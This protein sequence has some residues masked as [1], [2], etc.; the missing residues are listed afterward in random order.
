ML[1]LTS[2]ILEHSQ[3]SSISNDLIYAMTAKI[4]RRLLKFNSPID[5]RILN[6]VQYTVQNANKFLHARWSDVMNRDGQAFDLSVLK[7]L[8]FPLDTRITLPKLDEYL[9]LVTQRKNSTISVTFRPNSENIV[10]L[11]T[12]LPSCLESRNGDY[13]PYKLKA[14][15]AWVAANLTL[16]IESHKEDPSTCAKLAKLIRNYYGMANSTYSGNVEATSIMILTILELWIACDESATKICET[17]KHYGF[18][19]DRFNF[20]GLV[21]P[22]KSQMERLFRA[23]NYLSRRVVTTHLRN[24]HIFCSFGKED[25]FSVKYFD[26]STQHQDLLKD[27]QRQAMEDKNQKLREFS[28]KQ[29][30]YK[31]FMLL[32]DQNDCE[33]DEVVVDIINDF[34]E[35]RHRTNCKK[36]KYKTQAAGL[37]IKIHEWPLP[38][39]TLEAKSVVF[40]LQAPSF[41]GHWRDVTLY[42]KLDVLKYDYKT[43][44]TPSFKYPLKTYMRLSSFFTPFS[45]TQRIGLL[46]ETKPHEVTHRRDKKIAVATEDDICLDTGLLYKSYDDQRGCFVD[47]FLPTARVARMCMYK[48]PARSSSLQEFLFRPTPTLDGPK[49]NTVIASQSMCPAHMSFD[50]FKALGTIPQLRLQWQNILLQLSVPTVD[51]KTDETGLVVLQAIYQTGPSKDGNVLRIGHEIL[52]DESFAHALLAAL[53]EALSRTKENWESSNALS[54][55]ISLASRLLSLTSSEHIKDRSLAYL[56]DVR[57]VSFHWVNLLRERT[58]QAINDSQRRDL[59][60]KAVEL[61]LICV[62]SFNLEDKY[63]KDT[64]IDPETAS[65]FIQ[66]SIV[67]QEGDLSTSKATNTLISILSNRWK[68]NA[69]RCYLILEKELL[70]SKA[71]SLDNAIKKSWSAYQS[72]HGWQVYGKNAEYWLVSKTA[73]GLDGA[74]NPLS[75][76]FNLLTFELLVNGVPLARLPS[77]YESHSMYRILF[78]YSAVEV[79]PTAVPG[80]RYSGKKE[81]YGYTIHFGF[82]TVAGISENDLLVQA[83]KDDR[84]YE[85]LPRRVFRGHFPVAFVEDFIHWYDSTNDSVEFR[86]IEDPWATSSNKFKNYWRLSR[87]SDGR[88]WHLNRDGLSLIGFTS[89]TA[90][91]L[92]SILAPIENSPHIHIILHQ[93]S[94]TLEIEL[95]RIQLGFNLSSNSSTIQS[96]QFRGMSIDSSQS[97]GTLIGFR[98]KLILKH[99]HNDSRLIVLL[100]GNVYCKSNG[101]HVHVNIDIES[102]KRTHAFQVDDLIGRLI[103][104]GSLHSKLL[105][106]YLHALTS[107]C[108][109]DPLLQRT[110]T[111][112]ALSILRSAA[113]RS[114]DRLTEENVQI[115]TQL[116]QLTPSRCYYPANER[117]MQTVKW[118]S[119][120]DFLAQHGSFYKYV[121]SIFDQAAATSFFHPDVKLPEL[122]HV[123]SDLLERESMRS[124]TF[125]VSGFGAKEHNVK[126]DAIYTARDRDQNSKQGLNA[127]LM[128]RLIYENRTTLHSDLQ[129]DFINNLWGYLKRSPQILGPKHPLPLSEVKYDGRLLSSSSAFISRH[130]IGLHRTL[131]TG[132]NEIKPQ[133]MIWLSTLAF[134]PEADMQ[135]IQ[136]LSSFCTVSAMAHVRHPMV[137]SFRLHCG[138]KVN[139]AELRTTVQSSVLPLA[140]SPE[141]IFTALADESSFEFK[142]R[143]QKQFLEKQ[144]HALD[145]WTEALEAQ[146]PCEVPSTPIDN[147]SAQ[148]S[149]YIDITNAM[150][151]CKA[152]FKAWFENDQFLQYIRRINTTLEQ[153]QVSPLYIPQYSFITPAYS[154]RSRQGFISIDDLFDCSFPFVPIFRPEN[155]PDL[156][157]PITGSSET[158]SRLS[159]LLCVFEARS[160]S[161]FERNYAKD[162]RDSQL[163]LRNCGPGYNLLSNEEEIKEILS[164]HLETCKDHAKK[165]YEAIISAFTS[166]TQSNASAVWAQ[167]FPTIAATARQWPR[168]SPVFLLQQLAR[169]RWEKISQ[170]WKGCIV[171]YAVALS[172][173]QRAERL[174]KLSGKKTD[175]IKE[176]QNPGHTNWSPLFYPESLLLEVESGIMIREVQEHIAAKM[177]DPPSGENAVMQLNMGEGKSSVIVPIV[178]AALAN[179]LR[180]VRV[181]VA[182]PQSKQMLEMLVSKLGGLLDRRVYHMPF[183]RALQLDEA[184]AN[185]IGNLYKECMI[186]GG[187]LLVQPEHILSFKLMCLECLVLGKGSVGNSLLRTQ[188]FFDTSSRD[189]V[190]ESDENFS[191]KFELIYT[192]GSQ[193]PIE[194]SPERW[195]CIQ[196]VLAFVKKF[197]L[198]AKDEFPNAID[199]Y[200]AWP[201]SFP[202]IRFLRLEAERF[203]LSKIAQHICGT[204]LEGFPISRQPESV[205]Q[206]VFKYITKLNPTPKEISQVEKQDQGG[207]WAATTSSTLLLLRGLLAGGILAFAFN[208]KRWKVNYGLDTTRKP[209]TKLAVPYRAKDNPTPRSEFSH[210]DVVI[211]FTCLSYYYGGLT[212]DELFLAFN[213][214]L[215]SDQADIEYHAWVEDAVELEEAFQLL[216]GINLKDRVQCEQKVFPSLRHAKG[217]IDY[218]LAHVVFPKEMKEFPHKLSTSGWDVGATKPFPTTGFSGTI[219]SRKLLP[220][221]VSHVDLQE[222]KHT[223]ALVLENLLDNRNSVALMPP[224]EKT[225]SSD[226]QL[227]L[228][229]VTEMEIQ[230]ILDVGAQILE[231]SNRDIAKEWLEMT[232]EIKEKQAVVFFN[233]DDEL[234]VLDRKGNIEPLQTSSFAKQL[235]LCLVFLDEAHTRGTDLKLPE[236]YRA[237]VTLGPNLTKDRLVQGNSFTIIV[238]FAT[239]V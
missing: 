92:S 174:M 38:K 33:F 84:Q 186:T 169:G 149:S 101:N 226:A 233:D 16:W 49:P 232:S 125:R 188:H 146:W 200:E 236:Y 213:H 162:L 177:R 108:L 30:Q 91:R 46:S 161:N 12:E 218:F 67:I 191:P 99:E 72:G 10:F 234:S 206:A 214:L 8:D 118:S 202:R 230:V 208:S 128:S 53:Y 176:L 210:P 20:Q 93:S 34:R 134:A 44:Q 154:L 57:H 178:A 207:F 95:P 50:E 198:S 192:M 13:V 59:G 221:S 231:L 142:K 97:L 3:K 160:R 15:E 168:L 223:N 182:K 216:I 145:K 219:D 66:C 60:S 124:S 228:A 107:F 139:K 85:L 115:L 96:R 76:H 11:A 25:S 164:E 1:V 68:G 197:A 166:P 5:G 131:S 6:L 112:L 194:F 65:V 47:G 103:D 98:N 212:N 211:V 4:S 181:I 109:P 102:A 113:V 144:N 105:L 155:A 235:D 42:F 148:F 201:G 87:A 143:Q 19:I 80:L 64:L 88:K 81:F 56:A 9:E 193:Q 31:K 43:S 23:E 100:E 171:H 83:T 239:N 138:F 89:D 153:Q 40:E 183:S 199:I 156:L 74:G 133:L 22:F 51:F 237:A 122:H 159:T 150:K 90:T 132:S 29:E 227:L 69:Y 215:R 190:D 73:S 225:S 141:A 36:C 48:L 238:M 61:A 187:V 54:I 62:D 71:P 224:R 220:L 52:N 55:F 158:T 126:H 21:L 14:F 120:L 27:I 26:Q 114:F 45:S 106:A 35:K 167:G 2:Y 130:W 172:D 70:H 151:D 117:V 229:M 77:V 110:G 135:I 18:G 75:V 179:N 63:M 41:F 163:S 123:Q 204:G 79:M 147:K 185:A 217:A 173:L 7:S 37:N 222:Q 129:P 137:D 86:P 119:S 203:I 196:Q 17:L 136:T 184:K 140:R 32:Y 165:V 170:G 111:E 104:N 94:L 209:S 116:A 82:N 121:K 24:P 157:S 127:F 152:L 180:L 78:G 205:R 195:T 39:N 175:L 28:Q 58:Q 189:I